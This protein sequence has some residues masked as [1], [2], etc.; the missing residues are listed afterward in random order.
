MATPNST[1]TTRVSDVTIEPYH[2]L[3]SKIDRIEFYLGLISRREQQLI[4]QAATLNTTDKHLDQHL[5]ILQLATKKG[6][7]R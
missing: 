7:K 4:N 6:V 5:D 1:V 3:V 2:D